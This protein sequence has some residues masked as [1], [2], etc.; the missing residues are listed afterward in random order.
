MHQLNHH[1]LHR[2][3][4]LKTRFHI[5]DIVVSGID[6]HTTEKV[7]ALIRQGI[8]RESFGQM[9]QQSQYTYRTQAVEEQKQDPLDRLDKVEWEYLQV[10]HIPS[11]LLLPQ[12]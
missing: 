8:R 4:V 11:L 7:D 5:E 9:E 6:K 2:D 10:F 1:H 3:I 12:L